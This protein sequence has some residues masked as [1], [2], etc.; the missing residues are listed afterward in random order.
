M[1]LNNL[2]ECDKLETDYHLLTYCVIFMLRDGP[3]NIF[4]EGRRTNILM[5]DLIEYL[6]TIFYDGFWLCRRQSTF[7]LLSLHLFLNIWHLNLKYINNNFCCTINLAIALLREF[8]V[9]K[10]G[11]IFPLLSDFYLIVWINYN[12]YIRLEHIYETYLNNDV[13]E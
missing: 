2:G 7:L 1:Q 11:S 9:V 12:Q 5:Y 10:L 8:N 6:I 3:R 13:I 4:L